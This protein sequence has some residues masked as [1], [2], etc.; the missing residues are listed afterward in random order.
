MTPEE[1]QELVEL[2]KKGFDTFDPEVMCKHKDPSFYSVLTPDFVWKDIKGQ[3]WKNVT[4]EL[5]TLFWV[6]G[7]DSIYVPVERYF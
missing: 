6:L 1:R 4:P 3:I 5:Y 2:Y 7:L